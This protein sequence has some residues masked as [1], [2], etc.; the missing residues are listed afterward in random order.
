MTLTPEEAHGLGIAG[1]TLLELA[2][3]HAL[4]ADFLGLIERATVL[5]EANALNR[6]APRA[7]S[8]RVWARE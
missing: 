8:D 6:D 4:W 5:A 3:D 7:G 1:A 2:I